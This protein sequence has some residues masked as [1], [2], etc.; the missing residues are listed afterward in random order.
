MNKQEMTQQNTPD[1]LAQKVAKKIPYKQYVWQEKEEGG[2]KNNCCVDLGKTS[3]Y[4]GLQE[5]K[6]K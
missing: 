3:T 4:Q 1:S 6:R 2:K 5:W